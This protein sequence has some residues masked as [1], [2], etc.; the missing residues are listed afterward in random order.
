ME[1]DES[2]TNDESQQRNV[3]GSLVNPEE[4]ENSKASEIGDKNFHS[5]SNSLYCYMLNGINIFILTLS[6][7]F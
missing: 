2:I 7:I 6:C 3:Y 1:V 5:L 4:H